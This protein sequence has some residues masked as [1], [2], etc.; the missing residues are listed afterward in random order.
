MLTRLWP[1][2]RGRY[3]AYR[4]RPRAAVRAVGRGDCAVQSAAAADCRH[5]RDAG[6]LAAAMTPVRCARAAGI[7]SKSRA[8][9]ALG[10]DRERVARR[11]PWMGDHPDGADPWLG[12][13]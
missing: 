11:P 13:L 8:T 5:G 6:R 1:P 9:A 7:R 3:C 2:D 4:D 12:A 10:D